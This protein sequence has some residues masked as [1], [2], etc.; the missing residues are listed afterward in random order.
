M[1]FLRTLSHKDDTL[2]A[3]ESVMFPRI[4][5]G[6]GTDVLI[7]TRFYTNRHISAKSK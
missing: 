1:P 3:G 5:T 4:V 2:G 7:L 6:N